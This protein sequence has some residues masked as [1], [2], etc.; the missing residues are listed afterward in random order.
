MGT[1]GIL[2]LVQAYGRT[3]ACEPSQH[4][5]EAPIRQA[6]YC[7]WHSAQSVLVRLNCGAE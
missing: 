4:L 5:L 2:R 7:S 1:V 6:F 3:I